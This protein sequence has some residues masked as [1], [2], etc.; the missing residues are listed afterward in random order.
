MAKIMAYMGSTVL[1]VGLLV[2]GWQ[3]VAEDKP[4]ISATSSVSAYSAES[5]NVLLDNDELVIPVAGLAIETSSN[6]NVAGEDVRPMDTPQNIA[7]LNST[8]LRGTEIDGDYP[9]DSR[10]QL[11]LSKAIKQRFDYFLSLMGEKTLS[12]IDALVQQDMARTLTADAE[13]Q[14]YE[15]WQAYLAY[16]QA[17]VQLE[18]DFPNNGFAT[19]FTGSAFERLQRQ[20][21]ELENTR[22]WF[23][24]PTQITA[25]F[26]DD[27]AYDRLTLEKIALKQNTLLT[28]QEKAAR[29]DSL[30]QMEAASEFI[31]NQQRMNDTL[32]T[33]QALQANGA[34]VEEVYQRHV[35]A[36]GEPAAQRLQQVQQQRQRF[37]QKVSEYLEEKQQL[38]ENSGLSLM[39]KNTQL[40]ALKDTYFSPLEQKRLPA[41]EAMAKA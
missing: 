19:E 33:T 5:T 2:I 23:F 30:Q 17:L 35:A 20:F 9:L 21:S 14:A 38:E 8:S 40:Q 13:R 25:F 18:A 15:L 11:L 24:T 39:E 3:F 12:E 16:R 10:G 1:G 34:S 28:P 7:A 37:S 29:L 27:L 22:L 41:L 36:F 4:R 31:A 26:G 6:T 32:A